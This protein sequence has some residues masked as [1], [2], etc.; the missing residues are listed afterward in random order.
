M[1]AQNPGDRRNAEW[2][3]KPDSTSVITVATVNLG[4]LMG[5][6]SNSWPREYAFMQLDQDILDIDAVC[7]KKDWIVGFGT[8]EV[9]LGNLQTATDN[10]AAA[11]GVLTFDDDMRG[12]VALQVTTDPP[13]DDGSDTRVI[14]ITYALSIGDGAFAIPNAR[15]GAIQSAGVQMK[16]IAAASSGLLGTITDTYA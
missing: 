16:A 2:G 3:F 14:A 1:A 10:D 7:I 15:S 13:N 9:L 8:D 4:F 6:I 12:A 11:A 5:D